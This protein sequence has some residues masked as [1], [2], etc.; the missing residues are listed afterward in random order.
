VYLQD[1]VYIIRV[2][3]LK[4]MMDLHSARTQ[5]IIIITLNAM[6][7][8]HLTKK[9]LVCLLQNDLWTQ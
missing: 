1:T 3:A 4:T 8:S 7:T 9:K 5:K 6:K 2:E